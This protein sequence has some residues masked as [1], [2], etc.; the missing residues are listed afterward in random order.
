MINMPPN[1]VGKTRR[2]RCSTQ[3][4]IIPVFTSS[5]DI[6]FSKSKKNKKCQ[7]SHCATI[8]E[9]LPVQRGRIALPPTSLTETAQIKFFLNLKVRI[10]VGS[11]NYT[12]LIYAIQTRFT[13][14]KQENFD[15]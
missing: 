10:L 14:I 7:S 6:Q 3:I 13:L 5:N 15:C 2:I 11:K 8:V 4:K 12:P 1:F 9:N